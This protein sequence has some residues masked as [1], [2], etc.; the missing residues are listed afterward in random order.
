MDLNFL[1]AVYGNKNQILLS[2][3][4]IATKVLFSTIAA[5]KYLCWDH[6]KLPNI[7]VL[8][9]NGDTK[10]YIGNVFYA[11]TMT[12]A[13]MPADQILERYRQSLKKHYNQ[14]LLR[15]Y[16][17]AVSNNQRIYERTRLAKIMDDQELLEI[18]YEFP[19]SQIP[20]KSRIVIYG[21]GK[22][23][24]DIYAIQS[25]LKDYSITAWVDK[26]FEKLDNHEIKPPQFLKNCEFDF[27]VVAVEKIS[28]FQEICSY[29][30]EKGLGKEEQIIG[31]IVRY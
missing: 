7:A 11:L 16:D 28:I 30:I 15:Y 10:K 19:Y 31:P 29:I 1:R 2:K 27:I 24:C 25:M 12:W 6:E 22:V 17:I 8:H 4:S 3:E 9:I 23:G 26:N 20:K 5:D 18:R 13:Y 21:A 14:E